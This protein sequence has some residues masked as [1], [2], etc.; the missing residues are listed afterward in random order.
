MDLGPSDLSVVIFLLLCSFTVS[1]LV[2]FISKR[3]LLWAV[4]AMSVLSNL[5]IKLF[6]KTLFFWRYDLIGF[7]HFVFNQWP[8]INLALLVIILAQ[9]ILQFKKSKNDN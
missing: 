9:V 2:Y 6:D 4:F 3:K 7:K 1:V 8:I 5:S